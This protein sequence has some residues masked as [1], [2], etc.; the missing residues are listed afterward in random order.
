MNAATKPFT[1]IRALLVLQRAGII[2]RTLAGVLYLDCQ[3]GDHIISVS[4]KT[5]LVDLVLG[6]WRAA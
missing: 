4:G 2:G 3:G 1:R 5:Y 6:K